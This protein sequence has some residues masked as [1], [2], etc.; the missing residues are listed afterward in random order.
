MNRIDLAGVLLGVLAVASLGNAE[1]QP[2][3]SDGRASQT[4]SPQSRFDHEHSSWTAILDQYVS[5]GSV[6]Y[7]GLADRGQPALDA[8]LMALSAASPDESLWT[9]EERLAFWINAY[10]A[11]TIRLILDH[12]P[13]SSIR[14]IGFLPMAAFR[15]KF[16][17]LGADQRRISLNAVENDI[18]REQFNDSRIHFAI[19]CASK[20]CPTLRSEAYRSSVIDQQLDDAARAFLDDPSKNR[21]ELASRTLHLSSIFKW[22]R[23]DFQR[24]ASTLPAY[25]GRYM[26]QLDQAALDGGK[27]RVEFLD[28]DWSLNGH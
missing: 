18:L 5:S 17:P 7:A 16:I 3:Q 12:Y 11:S 26:G 4:V 1:K 2:G 22:F 24:D 15:T 8:Y 14:S 13:L 28:Y 9:R 10:N 27:V 19:V 23:D 21:W 20:S 6:D 25:A